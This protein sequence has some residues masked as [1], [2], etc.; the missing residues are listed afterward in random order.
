MSDEE[1]A[2]VARAVAGDLEAFRSLHASH[3]ADVHRFLVRRVGPD[4]AEDLTSETFLSA[5]RAIGSYVA[6]GAPFRAWLLRIALRQVLTWSRRRS[7]SEL[8]LA[9]IDLPAT[10]RLD[11]AVA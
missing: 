5:W 7:A 6:A 1:S 3:V 8:P 4:M 10:G 2:I 9:E 11:V